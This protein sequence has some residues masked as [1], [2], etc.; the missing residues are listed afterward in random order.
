[1]RIIKEHSAG[2]IIDIQERLHPHIYHHD[3]LEM[4]T[5]ILIK[6]LK[7]LEIPILV[8]EQY[9]KGLGLT[10]PTLREILENYEALE[11]M[12]F[13]CCDDPAFE[14]ELNK[15]GKTQIIIAGIETHVCVLQTVVDLL[16][17]GFQPVVVADC[18]SSRKENDKIIALER[19][20]QEGAIITSF[21]SLLFELARVSGTAIFKEI[22]ALVK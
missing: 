21:E 8:T 13:S 17:F 5:E 11:K 14:I 15:T 4:N 10:I 1:M 16:E 12:S 20:R 19:M 18:V 3:Q 7:L 2:L 6:G 9:P 22:S